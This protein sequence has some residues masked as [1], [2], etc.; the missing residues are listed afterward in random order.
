MLLCIWKN[1]F[2][3]CGDSRLRS[4]AVHI[5]VSGYSI[6]RHHTSLDKRIG[7]T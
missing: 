2:Q 3:G 1:G 7:E 4:K 6:S 5:I